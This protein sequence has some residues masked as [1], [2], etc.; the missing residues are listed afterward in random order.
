MRVT[1]V[2]LETFVQVA[3]Q[4]NFSRV[5]E[6]LHLTQPAVTQQIRGLER[7][8]GVRLVDVVGRRVVLTDAGSFLAA[9]ATHVLAGIDLLDQEMAE[10]TE[11]RLG[12]LTIGA[13][14]TIGAYVLPTLLARFVARYPQLQVSVEIANTAA[15]V[16]RV[17]GG[18]LPLALVEGPLDGDGIV[19]TAFARDRLVLVVPPQHPLA[20]TR[21]IAPGALEGVA[22]I[23]R[24]R[25]SGTRALAE[26]TLARVG[27]T[28]HLVLELPTGEGVARAVEAGMGVAILSEFVVEQA[29][30]DGRLVVVALDGLDLSRT[31]RLVMSVGRTPSPAANAF[32]ALLGKLDE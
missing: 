8:L 19:S 21:S 3:E 12:H 23:C 22:M 26:E 32:T 18:S 11:A 17:R 15:T 2:Q 30:H 31:F 13:T 25:G 28:P 4:R 14:L 20:N 10:F 1:L 16:E 29:A 7:A 5:A 6:M 9:R 27:V 24:E